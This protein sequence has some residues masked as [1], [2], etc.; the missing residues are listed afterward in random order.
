MKNARFERGDL[1][2]NLIDN[3]GEVGTGNNREWLTEYAFSL[4]NQSI[5]GIDSAFTRTRT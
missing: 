5:P 2:P 4:A 3:T 1:R